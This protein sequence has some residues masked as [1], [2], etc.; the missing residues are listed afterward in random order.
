MCGGRSA[1]FSRTEAGNGAGEGPAAGPVAAAR[2]S[3]VRETVN[4]NTGDV[5][6]VVCRRGR[7]WRGAG[8]PGERPTEP[9][10]ANLRSSGWVRAGNLRLT[11]TRSR[12]DRRLRAREG[13][14][15]V[16]GAAGSDCAGW[17]RRWRQ[18]ERTMPGMG[19]GWGRWQRST[20]RNDGTAASPR[21]RSL[22]RRGWADWRLMRRR[23]RLGM[24]AG[25]GGRRAP[26]RAGFSVGFSW[27]QKTRIDCGA[28]KARALL[29][30]GSRAAA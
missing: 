6:I 16:A 22:S 18:S 20:N 2:R 26:A 30:Q 1:I 24:V 19:P 9:W 23:P 12:A 11:T 21:P 29:D 14:E 25:P 3:G 8:W 13:A 15:G 10:Q 4:Q 17:K 7:S 28:R 5:R 27:G